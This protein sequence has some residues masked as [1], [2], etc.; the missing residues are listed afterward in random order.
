MRPIAERHGLSMLQLS[1]LW[2][3]SQNP[4]KSVVPTLIQEVGATA[5]PIE[6][7]LD[8]L[9]ALP[10]VTLSEDELRTIAA[11][12]N[13]KGCMSLKG[14][15]PEHSGDALPDRWQLNPDLL[16]VAARWKIQPGQDLVCTHNAVA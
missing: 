4:V 1:C 3:L 8:E 9:A 11:I 14:G 5:K 16:D 2:D 10:E 13:N 15:N 12:G 6:A 7:K